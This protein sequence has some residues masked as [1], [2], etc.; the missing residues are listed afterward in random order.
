MKPG[1]NPPPPNCQNQTHQCLAVFF[2][3]KVVLTWLTAMV[4]SETT[5][6]P[7]HDSLPLSP[8]VFSFFPQSF[9]SGGNLV[10]ACTAV[11]LLLA[12]ARPPPASAGFIRT[13]A[14]E[15]DPE[16]WAPQQGAAVTTEPELALESSPSLQQVLLR[17]ARSVPAAAPYPA[18]RPPSIGE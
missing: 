11:G 17:G 16:G 3:F 5:P 10:E 15:F 7:A 2:E 12:A 8:L 4:A 9:F 18:R 14:V 6:L 1:I 13:A